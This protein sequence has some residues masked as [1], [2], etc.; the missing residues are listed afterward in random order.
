MRNRG[1]NLPRVSDYNQVLIV[2]LIRRQPGISRVELTDQTGLAGQTVTN[3]CR[4]LTAEGLIRESGRVTGDLGKRRTV[5]E[6]IPN[7]K[8][9]IGLHIDPARTVLA[10]VDLGGCIVDR[11]SLVNPMTNDP[12]DVI[13]ALVE[14]VRTLIERNNVSSTSLSGLGVAAPGPIGMAAGA[15]IGPPNLRGWTIVRLRDEL[16]ARLNIPVVLEKDTVAA[17]TGEVWA[18][19]DASNNFGFIYLGTGAGVGVVLGGEI[20]HGSSGNLGNFGHLTG[21]PDGPRCYCGDRGCL[22]VT[23]MPLDLV[24]QAERDGLIDSVDHDDAAEV[25]KAV[26]ELCRRADDGHEGAR[27]IVERAARGFARA[28][29]NLINTLDLDTV[30]FGG[31]NWQSFAPIF[32]RVV[33]PIV[34]KLHIFSDVHGVEIRG[35]TLGEDVGPI[36]AASLV[37]ANA[38]SARPS[39]LFLPA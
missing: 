36:G 28:A 18:D 8:C 10:L 27:I 31:P 21:D 7:S 19:S 39:H 6:I 24:K 12:A 26:A 9:A 33:P 11:L 22:A 13:D 16:S 29:A 4:R 35:T 23:A 25:E 5:Y 2:D 17:I 30:V 38:V 34:E 15:L 37:L 14:H 1:S 20:M 32:M 3:I